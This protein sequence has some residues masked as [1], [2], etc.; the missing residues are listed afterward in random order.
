MWALVEEGLKARFYSNREV[1]AQ[2]PK[3]KQAVESGAITPA[4]AANDLLSLLDKKGMR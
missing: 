1:T 4:A 2:V 3:I